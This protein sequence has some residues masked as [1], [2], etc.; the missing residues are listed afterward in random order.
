MTL[1]NK[2]LEIWCACC[3]NPIMK[4]GKSFPFI[5]WF[6]A[7]LTMKTSNPRKNWLLLVALSA[8]MTMT[9]FASAEAVAHSPA[10]GMIVHVWYQGFCDP[11]TPGAGP[12]CTLPRPYFGAFSIFTTAGKHV[13]SAST[14]Q[15]FLGSFT[16]ALT[17]GRYIIVPDDPL[18]VDLTT[19][20]IVR[21]H[22]FTEVMIWIP[23]N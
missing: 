15:D 14:T 22:G 9:R 7:L 20:V 11:P 19:I 8:V 10:A 2:A 6:G 12:F 5:K 23:P 3:S 18:L 16:V 21:G 17:P 1:K 13:A 4:N